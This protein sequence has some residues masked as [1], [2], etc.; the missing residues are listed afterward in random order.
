M[1]GVRN[2]VVRE[3]HAPFARKVAAELLR[4]GFDPHA[5]DEMKTLGAFSQSSRIFQILGEHDL[6]AVDAAF[7]IQMACNLYQHTR[8]MAAAR[9]WPLRRPGMHTAGRPRH[10]A[11]FLELLLEAAFVLRLQH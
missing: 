11:Y 3:R 4:E 6:S 9:G 2:L 7:A 1:L 8:K 10:E 5:L